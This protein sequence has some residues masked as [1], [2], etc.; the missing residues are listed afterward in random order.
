MSAAPPCSGQFCRQCW[1]FATRDASLAAS[2]SK[3]SVDQRGGAT[4]PILNSL[5][6]HY[7]KRLL[8]LRRKLPVTSL[9]QFDAVAS[10]QLY[11]TPV[12]GYQSTEWQRVWSTYCS[13][14]RLVS[15]R[16]RYPRLDSCSFQ[17]IRNRYFSTEIDFGCVRWSA[18]S[19]AATGARSGS[20]KVT[21]KRPYTSPMKQPLLA[22]FDLGVLLGASTHR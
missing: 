15:S 16:C 2:A 22:V 9:G 6:L 8:K 21:A 1:I 4:Q 19:L 17:H 3:L 12:L 20:M 13:I 11:R 5:L 7:Q 14:L 10:D 18:S